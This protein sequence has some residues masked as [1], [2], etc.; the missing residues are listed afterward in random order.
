MQAQRAP[1]GIVGSLERHEARLAP[2]SCSSRGDHLQAPKSS[3]I[4]IRRREAIN[5]LLN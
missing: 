2:H 4:I 1:K 5:L 3:P